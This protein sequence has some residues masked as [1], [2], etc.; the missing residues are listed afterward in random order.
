MVPFDGGHIVRDA[1]HSILRRFSSKHPITIEKFANKISNY[2][3]FFFLMIIMVP[4]IS[5]IFPW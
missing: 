3:S 2:S 4:L 1:V 5:P